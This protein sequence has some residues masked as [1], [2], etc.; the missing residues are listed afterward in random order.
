MN[1]RPITNF[2]ISEPQNASHD[3]RDYA[4]VE[5]VYQ[6]QTATNGM[7]VIFESTDPKDFTELWGLG[8]VPCDG[9]GK[10]LS[11]SG[12]CQECVDAARAKLAT[13]NG[14]MIQ[15]SIRPVTTDSPS[16]VTILQGDCRHQEPVKAHVEYDGVR[17]GVSVRYHGEYES[18]FPYEWRVERC[19]GGPG[20]MGG[21]ARTKRKMWG[22]VMSAIKYERMTRGQEAVS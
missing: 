8:S 22:R 11:T 7:T 1:T 4:T 2:S 10:P 9:C 5:A 21:V 15:P 13:W 16:S 20:A 17:Y 12:Y 18:S 14:T 19:S 6:R 3:E